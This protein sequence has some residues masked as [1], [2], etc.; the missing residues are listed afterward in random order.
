MG[1]DGKGGARELL[2]SKKLSKSW[3][4]EVDAVKQLA[5]AVFSRSTWGAGYRNQEDQLRPLSQD[6]KIGG[7]V[8]ESFSFWPGEFCGQRILAG[9]S[10]WGRKESG[11]TE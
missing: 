8:E 10:P 2:I 1:N 9:Y 6:W 7:E 4:A 11:T 3:S 5:C